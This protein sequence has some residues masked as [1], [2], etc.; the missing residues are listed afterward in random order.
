MCFISLS[1]VIS[2]GYAENITCKDYN[3][4]PFQVKPKTIT[5]QNNSEGI[6]YPV[7]STSQNAVN[8]WVQACFRTS[9]PYPSSHVYKIF[10]NESEGL[11]PGQSVTVTL[12]LYSET[13]DKQFI[14]WWNGGRVVLADRNKALKDECDKP[15]EEQP[16]GVSCESSNTS[17][18]LSIYQSD[19]QFSDHIYA[20]LSEFT[21]GDSIIPPKQN[22]RLL[23]PENV[24]YNISYV[25]H[26]YL[27]V[28]IE[29][30]NNPYIGYSGSTQTLQNFR[31]H[32]NTF[33]STPIGMGW[34][35]YNIEEYK[36]AGGYNIFAQRFGTLPPKVDVPVKPAKGFPP[37]LTVKKC[38]EGH[39]NDEERASLHFG[40]SVQNMQNLWGSCTKWDEDLSPYVTNQIDCPQDLRNKLETIQAF[41]KQNHQNYLDLIA[42]KQCPAI[43][44]QSVK[45]VAFNFWETIKHVYGWV[46]FNEG[47]GA[48]K[49]P[50]NETKIPGWDHAKIQEMYIHD[51]QNNGLSSTLPEDQIFNPY[52]R[53]IHDA[54]YLD[55]SAYAFSVDDAVGFMSELGDGLVFT[56]G[57]SEG[58][59]NG[60]S[61]NYAEGFSVA[62]GVPQSQV[63]QVN[64]PL[65]KKY[66]VCVYHTNSQNEDCGTVHQDVM[67]PSNSQ[68]A[69]FRVGTVESY[70]IRVRFTDAENNV[71]SFDVD[72]EFAPC[73]SSA[74]PSTCPVNRQEIYDPSK[75][76]VI[77]ANGQ[78]HPKSDQWCSSANPNQSRDKQITKNFLSFSSPVKFLD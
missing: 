1:L 14:T 40:E 61:F 25:D 58:L 45:P 28:A 73:P 39:C 67:M 44:N 35:V 36:L 77:D 43:N 19:L 34:P 75:C 18:Q 4:K 56:V 22:L 60:K 50:L 68:V 21:F 49:N 69:G 48:A 29:P 52:V 71:Y 24:G 54:D 62:I 47:C 17:C 20:Q 16:K 27:P 76:E 7:I 6:I 31:E 32:L 5:V 8:E 78:K 30:K 42:A 13:N 3:D 26:V 53:L 57:G 9:D 51:L 59:T 66:G 38:L 23:K 2:T 12:P 46:P 10:I 55:M 65:I 15:L 63:N 11:A 37:V 74:D 64:V 72:H 33:L 41:Y 70:P